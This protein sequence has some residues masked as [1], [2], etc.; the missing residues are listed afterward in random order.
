MSIRGASVKLRFRGQRRRGGVTAATVVLNHAHPAELRL[1]AAQARLVTG[2]S[3]IV[4]VDGGLNVCRA[5]RTAPDLFVGDA[6]SVSVPPVGL[7]ELRFPTD[8]DFSDFAAAL[9]ELVA[10]KIEVVTVAGLLGGRLDHEWSNLQEAG[11]WAPN[12]AGILATSERGTVAI[13]SRGC[14]AETTRGRTVSLFPLGAAPTVT[15]R[16]T[17]WELQ[18]RR[19]RPGSLG[20]SNITG[21]RLDL[22][23]HAGTVALVFIPPNLTGL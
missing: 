5:A 19:V 6:D 3:M 7:P 10:R 2:R 4:A 1:A 11:R 14:R 15:L 9:R 8:K 16:G 12:F 23:V 20:L 18:R 13:T 17:R 22:N 21:T